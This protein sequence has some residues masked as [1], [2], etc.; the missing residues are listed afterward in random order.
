M[1]ARNLMEKNYV[2][3]LHKLKNENFMNDFVYFGGMSLSS[4]LTFVENDAPSIYQIKT[5]I[6]F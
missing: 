3:K 2:G 4:S 6:F 1:M 5:Q